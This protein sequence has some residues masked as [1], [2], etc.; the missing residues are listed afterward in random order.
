M[1]LLVFVTVFMNDWHLQCIIG[2]FAIDRSFFD[3]FWCFFVWQ[4]DDIYIMLEWKQVSIHLKGL[5]SSEWLVGYIWTWK[6][7]LPL[8]WLHQNIMSSY[9]QWYFLCIFLSSKIPVNRPFS[10]RSFLLFV[11]VVDAEQCTGEGRHFTK[12]DEKWFVDLSFR[13]DERSDEQQHQ[14]TNGQH[15]C[16][17]QLNV[18]LH[19]HS[20][21]LGRLP[22][23]WKWNAVKRFFERIQRIRFFVRQ[24]YDIHIGLEGEQVDIRL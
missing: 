23:F 17:D 7:R 6:V 4:Q 22:I 11:N 24:Q 16:G 8:F 21:L 9:Y 15:R 10:I 3:I 13:C 5:L 1:F 12:S 18:K 2:I 19:N 14:P 20:I